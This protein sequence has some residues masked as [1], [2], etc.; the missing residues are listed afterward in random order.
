MQEA[1]YLLDK[2]RC[3]IIYRTVFVDLVKKCPSDSLET[4]SVSV[5]VH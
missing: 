5:F 2:H 3:K 4:V 1:E